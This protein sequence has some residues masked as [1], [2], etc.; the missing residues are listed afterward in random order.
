MPAL[1]TAKERARR[2]VCRSNLRQMNLATL[3]YAGDSQEQVFAHTRD[4]G[5]WFTQCFSTPM[6]MAVSN[7]A[8]DRVLDCPNLY[9][10]T[11]TGLT[12][13]VGGRTQRGW[14]VNVGY[15][16]LGGITNMPTVTGW[17]S[18]IKTTEEPTMELFSDANNS[19]SLIGKYWAVVP[20]KSTGPYRQD[21]STFL[22]FD[23]L[24]TPADLG[25][26]GGNVAYLDGSVSWKQLKRMKG[27]Y[28]TWVGDGL[29]RGFW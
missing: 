3:I 11:L 19:A 12:D 6:Y 15:N 16:Y 18:P 25:A 5:D 26:D 20:H 28:W 2:S 14:G 10:F 7:Y 22:W 24:K 21:K 13:T 8:G 29:H 1:V 17:K 4:F 9:P 23:T 27:N